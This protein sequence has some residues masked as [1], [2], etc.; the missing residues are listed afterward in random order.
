MNSRS[1]IAS[2]E[3]VNEDF[4]QCQLT[5]DQYEPFLCHDKILNYNFSELGE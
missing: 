1:C 2:D 4:V 5:I 3:P